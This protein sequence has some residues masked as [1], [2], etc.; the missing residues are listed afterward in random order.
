MSYLFPVQIADAYS[1]MAEGNRGPAS[2]G[3]VTTEVTNLT[4]DLQ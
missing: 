4:Q 1:D 3:D 2:T